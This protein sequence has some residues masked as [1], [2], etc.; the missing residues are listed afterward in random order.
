[1]KKK[2]RG[3]KRS[4]IQLDYDLYRVKVPMRGVSDAYLSVLDLHPEGTEQTIMFVHGYA[5]VLESW[6][7]QINHFARYYR[8]VAPDLR[9]HG[10]SDAPYTE[11][12]M[13]EMVSDLQAIVEDLS[14]PEK[15]ILVAHSF[16]GSIAVEYA[17]AYADRLEKLVLIATAGEYPLPRIANLATRIPPRLVR[18]FWRY[19]TRF[20]AEF[21]VM[22]RLAANNMLH[23]QGW[24]L[25]RNISVP[26]LVITGEQDNYFP[27]TVFEDVGKMIP[28]AE[29]YDVGTAKHK[30]QLERHRAVTRAIERFVDGEKKGSW[31]QQGHEPGRF[32]ERIWLRSYSDDT[33]PSLPI[34]A[35]PLFTFLESTA[36]WMPKRTATIFYG[37]QLTYRQLNQKVNQFAH[38]LHGKGVCP[39]DRV[40]IVLPNMPQMVIAFYA[41]LK[42]GGVVVM[43]NPDANG[44]AIVRQVSQTQP[45]VMITLMVFDHLAQAIG[46][47]TQLDQFIFADIQSVVSAGVFKKLMEQWGG[48][49]GQPEEEATMRTN[50][51]RMDVLMQDAPMDQPPPT[52]VSSADLAAILFTSGTTGA[53][54]GVC[55]THRN[56]VANTLQARHWIPD[57]EYGKE[58]CLAVLPIIH[59]YGLINAMSLSIALAGT[60]VLLPIF[61]TQGVLEYIR[62]YKVTIFPGVP[63]MYTAINHFPGA[64]EYGLSSIKACVSGAAP[65]PVE[66]QEAFEKLTHGRLVEGYG[67][68]EA[69]PVTHANPLYGVRKPGSIGVPMPNTE[70]KIVDLIS[71][72]NLPPGE[73]GELVVRGPQVMQEYWQNEEA[74]AE[75]ID[76]DGWLDTGDVAL[77][78]NDGYFQIISRKQ[79]TILFGEYSV[80]PRDVEE[81]IYENAK[82]IEVAVVGVGTVDG[83]QKVKAFVVPQPSSDLTEEELMAFCR[84]RLDEYAVPWEI[85]FREALPKSFIGKVLRRMLVVES[86][87]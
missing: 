53:P 49:E 82:V 11:Y 22:Q 61:D 57:L 54:K 74:T 12:T 52:E 77:M 78:D 60:I 44:P 35:R 70:A 37:Q 20:D 18:P 71:G 72:E 58:V 45:K 65:L 17:N 28:N 39:G 50:D 25:M 15:F 76:A 19:R 46:D 81:V 73:I 3:V 36:G 62:D 1:M 80:Y 86:A 40:F 7:H 9:G 26:T 14:L 34:P 79:D 85:E 56:L 8:V 68:T 64:R 5:G 6:E 31:R 4:D 41:V 33:P 51:Q 2:L 66:V 24:S 55:L 47:A 43:P 63:S 21:H 48:I 10:Q 23:W 32:Q 16:G 84:S 67:L 83:E 29:I 42:I 38:V 27:R 59:S 87:S 69:S 13:A 30:V 75:A